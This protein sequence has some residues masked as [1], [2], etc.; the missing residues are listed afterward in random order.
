MI[1]D[2][3]LYIALIKTRGKNV[4]MKIIKEFNIPIFTRSYEN[5]FPSL[6]NIMLQCVIVISYLYMRVLHSKI[7]QL[8]QKS[9]IILFLGYK[10]VTSNSYCYLLVLISYDTHWNH[11]P[12]QSYFVGMNCDEK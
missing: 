3:S 9:M 10:A 6:Y 2:N 1:C 7:V 12:I 4:L 8:S 5:H 11:H